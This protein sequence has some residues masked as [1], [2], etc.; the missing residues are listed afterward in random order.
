M[1][2]KFWPIAAVMGLSIGCVDTLTTPAASNGPLVASIVP[3][4][5][6]V[7]AL[8]VP[9]GWRGEGR[10]VS[11]HGAVFAYTGTGSPF[12]LHTWTAPF[13]SQPTPIPQG[14]IVW[15]G[16]ANALGDVAGTF[17]ASSLKGAWLQTAPGS[18][19]FVQTP[20]GTFAS[21][22]TRVINDQREMAGYVIPTGANGFGSRGA[23][24]SAPGAAAVVLPLPAVG[25]ILGAVALS[26]NNTG[27]MVGYAWQTV[28]SG[29]S[30]KTLMRPILWRRTSPTSWTPEILPGAAPTLHSPATSINDAG[31]IA[32]WSGTV[33]TRWTPTGA[34]WTVES[35]LS[36]GGGGFPQV[37]ACGRIA[38]YAPIGG[39]SNRAFVWDG[40]LTVLPLPPSATIT[41]AN[42]VTTDSSSGLG[43]IIGFGQ[44]GKNGSPYPVRWTIPGC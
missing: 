33:L 41:G 2:V 21:V 15:G 39:S 18:W 16:G 10:T 36:G 23:Y 3:G 27:D 25:T 12:A 38:G 42:D 22:S 30:A 7:Q 14:G 17:G 34:A 43:V 20:Q 29:W 31:R 40:S 19:S 37:D 28:G 13:S 8:P 11:E 24:Y 26:M 5:I 4:S 32:G 6:T 9:G 44:T 35:V 1:P